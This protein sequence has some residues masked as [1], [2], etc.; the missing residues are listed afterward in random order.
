MKRRT[1]NR[2]GGRANRSRGRGRGQ[3]PPPPPQQQQ[4]PRVQVGRKAGNVDFDDD[5]LVDYEQDEDFFDDDDSDD[6]DYD[7]NPETGKAVKEAKPFERR[8]VE[9]QVL[10]MSEKSQNM[11]KQMLKEIHGSQY[12][13]RDAST[14]CDA[15]QRYVIQY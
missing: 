14:Y 10:H 5:D 9:M 15:G 1:P 13:M 3:A 2:G 11:V 6:P 7:P 8:K 4:Q 12:K